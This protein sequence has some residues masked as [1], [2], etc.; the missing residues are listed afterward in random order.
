MT[1]IK[2]TANRLD[3][4]FSSRIDRAFKQRI[5]LIEATHLSSEDNNIIRKKEGDAF[6]FEIMGNS[7]TAYGISMIENGNI[8]CTCPDHNINGNLC[9]H[10][11]FVLI[12]VLGFN[13][14]SVFTDYY[15]PVHEEQNEEFKISPLTVERCIRYMEHREILQTKEGKRDVNKE[16]PCPICLEDLGD[17]PLLWCKTQCGNSVHRSCFMK[18]CEKKSRGQATC[19]LCR[20]QWI[21]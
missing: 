19:V 8:H 11:L 1:T 4:Q 14:D 12:R 7:G 2:K 16:D 6:F 15:I 17:E 10:L 3:W 18:W 21:W 13:K 9:K 20:A 5:Y